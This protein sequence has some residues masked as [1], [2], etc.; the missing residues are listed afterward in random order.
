MIQHMT[1][2]AEAHKIHNKDLY[3]LGMEAKQL[4]LKKR[5]LKR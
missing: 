4:R 3:L 1:I 2:E 5:K